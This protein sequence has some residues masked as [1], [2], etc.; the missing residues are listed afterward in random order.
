MHPP[1]IRAQA[2]HIRDRGHLD[3]RLRPIGKR[4][5]HLGVEPLALPRIRAEPL[6]D[7]GGGALAV[8]RKVLRALAGGHDLKPEGAGPLD[9]F[10]DQGRLVAVR[11]RI[12]HPGLVGHPAQHR[13][14]EHVGLDGHHHDV[15]LPAERLHGGAHGDLGHARRLDD[16]I[17]GAVEEDL[18]ISGD[19]RDPA[20]DRGVDPVDGVGAHHRV[21]GEPGVPEGREAARHVAVRHDAGT[22]SP[23]RG[24]LADDHRAEPPRADHA[25]AHGGAGRLAR[26]QAFPQHGRP[27]ARRESRPGRPWPALSGLAPAPRGIDVPAGGAAGS[28]SGGTRTRR[29]R[30][31]L[32]ARRHPGPAQS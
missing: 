23:H 19:R 13:A 3:R 20:G 28:L 11:R 31:I 26:F 2:R 4:V 21:R 30:S 9:Q 17:D 22:R 25:D 14:H 24:Q 15:L 1:H 10:V 7:V 18:G 29:R 8:L 6:P 32:P 27:A 16:D 5:V 12:H